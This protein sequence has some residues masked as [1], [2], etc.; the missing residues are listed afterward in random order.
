LMPSTYSDADGRYLGFDQHIHTIAPGHA[1]Y[2]NFSGWDIYRSQIPLLAILQPARLEDMAQSIVLMY[3]QGGWIDR[4]PQI[5]LYTNDMIGSPL[6]IILSTTWLSGLHNFDINTAWQGM[7]K[8]ATAAPPPGKPYLG[9]EG[10]E[11][12]NSLHYLPADKVDY[13]S[14]A[15]T[16]EYT[17][18]YASLTRLARDLHKNADAEMLYQRA[19][20]YRNLFDPSTG[21]FRPRRADG[22]W[23]PDFN[24]AQDSHGFAEGTAWHY[25]TFAPADMAWLVDTMGSARFNQQLDAFFDY[26]SPGWYAQYYNALNETDFQAPYAFHFSGRPW[27]SQQVVSRVLRENYRDTPD[28]IPGN[29]DA[30]ATSSW[31]VL[32]MIGLYTVDPTSLAYEL[33]A[34]VFS[35]IV[36]HRDPPYSAHPFTIVSTTEAGSAYI[37]AVTING[38]SHAQNW[39]AF[40]EIRRG[41]TV[42]LTLQHQPDAT[43]GSRPE[44]APPSLSRP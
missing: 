9:E 16:L 22:S 5:N 6:S 35:R 18:A 31:A 2:T 11:W 27:K 25:S 42:K 37:H 26:P 19:L 23:M 7:L 13:G 3:Q 15:K 28:G 29:D 21:F 14:V 44:D 41:S 12:I 32:S 36:I 39:I 40:D 24:P 38:R 30:G 1:V 4:W 17:L 43:W 8:D 10:V 20:Y 33:V 34:P